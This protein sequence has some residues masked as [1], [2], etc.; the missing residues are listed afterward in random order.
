[1]KQ[2]K[3]FLK[4]LIHSITHPLNH[5]RRGFTLIEL[6]VVIL[7]IG[8]ITGIVVI[9][10]DRG[11]K[12]ARDAKR[13]ADMNSVASALAAYYSDNHRFPYG[14]GYGTTQTEAEQINQKI[15]YKNTLGAGTGDESL[16]PSYL[17]SLPLESWCTSDGVQDNCSD[18]Y[19]VYGYRYLCSASPTSCYSFYLV[20]KLETNIAQ[21]A[22]TCAITGGTEFRYQLKNG[23]IYMANC[24]YS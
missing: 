14:A 6:L 24:T 23:E 20:T 18:F 7:I 12:T 10:V 9:N 11:R 19:D 4:S 13:I 2:K 5:S 3:L 21:T 16:T 17:V 8:M 1:M 22:Q 15:A